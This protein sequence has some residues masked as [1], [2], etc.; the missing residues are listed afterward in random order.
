MKLDKAIA[1]QAAYYGMTAGEYQ[2]ASDKLAKL[3]EIITEEEEPN[4]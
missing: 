1:E 2:R 3:C 4:P